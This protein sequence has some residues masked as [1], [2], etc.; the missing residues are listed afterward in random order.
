[1]GQQVPKMEKPL[2][3]TKIRYKIFPSFPIEELITLWL[4]CCE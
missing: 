2:A 4:N 1:M 3:K